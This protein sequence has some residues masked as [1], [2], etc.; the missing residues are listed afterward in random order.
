MKQLLLLV[1]WLLSALYGG[2]QPL[3]T[4]RVPAKM[5]F[6]DLTLHITEGARRE[7]QAD[8]DALTANK[9]F[10]M[11]KAERAALYMPL[12]EKIFAE[13][14]LPDDFKYLAIQ[15]SGFIADAVST[16]QAVGFW[17][18]KKETALEMGLRVDGKVDERQ[19]ILAASRAAARYLQQNNFYFN[20]WLYA[21]Q[22]YQMGA[23]GAMQALGEVKGGQKKLTIDKK[24]YWYVKK[25]LAHKIAFEDIIEEL[26]HT[27]PTLQVY[28][29]GRGKTLQQIAAETNS[30]PQELASFNTW[31]KTRKIP[32]DKA[33]PV[34]LPAGAQPAM[35][36][37]SPPVD[38]RPATTA[39]PPAAPPATDEL[40]LP[41]FNPIRLN[42]LQGV[43]PNRPMTIDQLAEL[44][45][46]DAAK[47]ARYNDL[48][49]HNRLEPG[50]VYYTQSK[51]NKGLIYY[52]TVREG[53]TPWMIAQNYG[54]KLTKLLKMNRLENKNT[55]LTPG[56][57]LWLR[58]NKPAGVADDYFP[59]NN[60][61]EK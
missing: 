26:K 46:T 29:D 6:A 52:H 36:A 11:A 54:I 30:N 43:I 50:Q 28:A 41:P 60:S 47:L 49:P 3:T 51:R 17:Q 20:N 40:N 16:S 18:F 9:R 14:G 56:L 34:I 19:H 39:L 15:E 10:F 61:G 35:L 21:L 1:L 12:V 58:K 7:I 59:A 37:A 31:L 24:T 22:A 13:E 57:V 32:D 42:G 53:E 33:Y 5:T 27:Q 55:L 44:L 38:T 23:G 48:L 25:S 8:V 4:P 2:S 45:T